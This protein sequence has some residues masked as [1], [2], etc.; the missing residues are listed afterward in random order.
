[1]RG[2]FIIL[3]T[4]FTPAGDVDWDDLVRE[5]EFVDRSGCAGVVWP[6]GSSGVA[7]LTAAERRRGMEV[8]AQAMKGK[9]GTLVLGVQGRDTGEMLEYAKRAEA[10]GTGAMIAMPPTAGTSMDDYR[11]YFRALAGVTTRPV[12]IQTSG[13]APRLEPSTDLIIALARE[14]PHM[15]YV[16][17][18]SDP[19]IPRMR[20]ELASRPVMRGVFGA[21]LGTGLLYEMRLGLDGIITG[22]GMYADLFA[23]M[24]Q[25]HERGQH[26]EAR[27][28]YARFLLMRNLNEAVPGTDLYI[29]KKRG[30]F[31]TTVRRTSAP[32]ASAPAKLTEFKPDAIELAEIEHRFASLAPYLSKS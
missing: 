7:T 29:M 31:K 28:A 25:M 4:P 24:W 27:D 6:Q 3:N 5:T 16:K 10:L 30:I 8:L 23:N 32:T 13:G 9:H 21:S 18:E 20:A 12:I 15:A 17:E 22:M 14:F 19:L 1:M 11:A 26:D 2:P